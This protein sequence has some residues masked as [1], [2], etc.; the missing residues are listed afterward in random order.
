MKTL[1]HRC[2]EPHNKSVSSEKNCKLESKPEE[3]CNKPDRRTASDG[4]GR[5]TAKNKK[6]QLQPG[7][8]HAIKWSGAIRLEIE[9]M[10]V[11]VNTEITNMINHFDE[12]HNETKNK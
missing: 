4:L 6:K 8:D 11:E 7:Q 5:R 1:E 3:I 12:F 10:P 9:S 2:V